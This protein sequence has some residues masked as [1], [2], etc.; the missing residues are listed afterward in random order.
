MVEARGDFERAVARSPDEVP[1]LTGLAVAYTLLG[2]GD[3]AL[4]QRALLAMDRARVLGGDPLA[5]E[6]AQAAMSVASGAA[7]QA[8]EGAQECLKL[9]AGDGLCLYYLG[10]SEL[11]LGAYDRAVDSLGRARGALGPRPGVEVSL[12][13]ARLGLGDYAQAVPV[14]EAHAAANPED[15][16]TLAMMAA[17][18]RE[19][20]QGR[21]ALD[22]A[23][24]AAALDSDLLR[25]RA[26]AGTLQLYVQGSPRVAFTT[27][28]ALTEEEG[29]RRLEG[30][31]QVAV[32]ASHAAR[33]SGDTAA[34]LALAE[35]A[36]EG[37]PASAP[38]RMAQA[39][40]RWASGD[41]GGAEEALQMA[42]TSD[43]PAIEV[44][45]FH[46]GAGEL[47]RAQD[48]QAAASGA[49]GDAVGAAPEW[50][51]GSLG[52]AMSRIAAGNAVQAADALGRLYDKDIR[53]SVRRDPVY[54]IWVQPIDIGAISRAAQPLF[55]DDARLSI[56][57]PQ[58]MG[59]LHAVGCL[60]YGDGARCGLALGQ[61]AEAIE[62][63]DADVVA[64]A[65][66]G[67]IKLLQ[68]NYAGALA[69][70]ERVLA[71]DDKKALLLAM[72]GRCL[73]A[74]GR[75]ADGDKAFK[76][77]YNVSDREPGVYYQHGEA[78]LA[79][80]DRAGA[81]ERFEALLELDPSDVTTRGRLL[82]LG[83]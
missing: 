78:L 18:W 38:G 65:F 67:R 72:Q 63:S 36:L 28:S 25:A 37:A 49:Y 12:A 82:A 80:G 58:V 21:K 83:Q 79:A 75:A 10:A 52:L 55:R 20:G 17:I 57:L 73:Y 19:L 15:P 32:D 29:F 7:V 40:A 62:A 81:R 35:L 11:A 59:V 56:Q 42:D 45:R 47:F 23:V 54:Q 51:V 48:R 8:M 5:L 44:A 30:W 64:H 46:F 69:H 2:R 16:D 53:R 9:A 31:R 1:A 66:A 68:G 61:L 22:Y 39:M 71:K 74:L 60:S 77:A 13:R 4:N 27:L 14:L 43:L 6:R 3:S 26:L 50:A 24:R 76:K 41:A 33:L 70:F 34:A